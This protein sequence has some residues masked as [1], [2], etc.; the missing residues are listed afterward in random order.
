MATVGVSLRNF[1]QDSLPQKP[2]ERLG[3]AQRSSLNATLGVQNDLQITSLIFWQ[4]LTLED[5]TS[6]SYTV[7]DIVLPMPR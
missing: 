4:A 3:A 6:Q 7:D 1:V 2:H 5:I